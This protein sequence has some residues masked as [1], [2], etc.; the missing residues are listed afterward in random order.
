[1][2]K[3]LAK[4]H[5]QHTQDEAN[6]RAQ[7]RGH[8]A[9]QSLIEAQ[10]RKT[11]EERSELRQ[12]KEQLERLQM[13]DNATLIASKSAPSL[14][15][16]Q[17]N[18]ILQ[19]EHKNHNPCSPSLHPYCTSSGVSKKVNKFGFDRGKCLDEAVQV[20]LSTENVGLVDT[21]N[22]GF[23]LLTH[24]KDEFDDWLSGEFG[25]DDVLQPNLGMPI[26]EEVAQNKDTNALH[27]RAGVRDDNV[28]HAH[29]HLD[30]EL[31]NFDVSFYTSQLSEFQDSEIR[32]LT[33]QRLDLLQ[34]GV[35]T[36]ED[37]IIKG[38]D[39]EIRRLQSVD[40]KKFTF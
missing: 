36:E 32:R 19:K 25:L 37:R 10:A 30:D 15:T 14:A 28:M 4:L 3:Q 17:N 5:K 31:K 8:L 39:Q 35:Y 1:M 26:G 12:L 38:L 9:L 33:K 22:Q 20:N 21:S 6:R 7:D 2:A 11:E 29:D 13:H 18:S 40:T 27:M 16:S 23:P 34:T 24:E